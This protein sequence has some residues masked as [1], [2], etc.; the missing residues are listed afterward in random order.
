MISEWKGYSLI[1]PAKGRSCGTAILLKNSPDRTVVSSARHC[2]GRVVSVVCSVSGK[3]VNFV[4]SYAPNKLPQKRSFFQD[5][6]LNYLE[7]SIPNIL[8][9]DFNCV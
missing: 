5:I 2:S 7:A 6:L 3:H 4:S 9:G 8:A 1:S